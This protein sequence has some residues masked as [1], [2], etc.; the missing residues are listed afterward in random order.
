MT[1]RKLDDFSHVSFSH[2]SL[3]DRHYVV[4][5]L[6]RSRFRCR[7]CG[8]QWRF[9]LWEHWRMEDLVR[10]VF[11]LHRELVDAFVDELRERAQA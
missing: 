11:Y 7:A 2:Q 1:V 8:A 5:G 10:H 9:W 4:K 3:L 6:L